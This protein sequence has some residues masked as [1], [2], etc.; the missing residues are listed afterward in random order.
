MFRR[1][2]RGFHRSVRLRF[3]PPPPCPLPR[4]RRVRFKSGWPLSAVRFSGLP[5]GTGLL[6]RSFA[7]R[8]VHGSYLRF[9]LLFVSVRFASAWFSSF[10]F[11]L[12]RFRSSCLVRFCSFRS[13]FVVPVLSLFHA[14]C[15]LTGDFIIYFSRILYT[16]W[17]EFQMYFLSENMFFL[18]IVQDIDI[19]L[20]FRSGWRPFFRNDRNHAGIAKKRSS[21]DV[22]TK[23]GR[24]R[25]ETAS[26]HDKSQW[27]K[28]EQKSL[29][30]LRSQNEYIFFVFLPSLYCF[31]FSAAVFI[32]QPGSAMTNYR[33]FEHI[34]IIFSHCFLLTKH[35][36]K[37]GHISLTRHICHTRIFFCIFLVN[38]SLLS[39]L[40]VS[41]LLSAFKTACHPGQ[42][43]TTQNQTNDTFYF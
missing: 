11:G 39:F 5:P 26:D 19:F 17:R 31:I 7:V 2:V 12:L 25:T 32:K 34:F 10:Q 38:N 20:G 18:R 6:F 9:V 40:F 1:R 21:F 30:S 4:R 42:T 41:F 24:T 16:T 29:Y 3:R 14:L 13:R 15:P 22:L 37:I 36:R 28:E 27:T 33:I 43:N 35:N 8:F 23:D